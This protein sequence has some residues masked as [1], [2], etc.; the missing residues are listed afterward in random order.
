MIPL[1]LD[2][3]G[4]AYYAGNGHKWL[5]GPKGSGFLWVRADR[6]ERIHP[7]IVSHGANDPRTDR[8]RFRL[9]FDWVGTADPTAVLSL[10]TAIDWLPTLDPGGW[11]GLMAANHAMALEARDRLIDGLGIQAPAP[12]ALLGSMAAIPLSLGEG[13]TDADGDALHDGLFAEDRVEVPVVGWPVRGA[14]ERPTDTPRRV[15]VRVSAQRYVESGDVER[16]VEAL[17]RRV[18]PG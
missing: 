4:A 13:A 18:G 17:G 8:P 1:A 12:D 7:T 2:A 5:C 11:P 14:R 10:P 6:R 16:L 9:E 15:L 3:L